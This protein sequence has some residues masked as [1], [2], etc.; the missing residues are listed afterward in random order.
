MEIFPV[1]F[2]KTIENIGSI[3]LLSLGPFFRQLAENLVGRQPGQV[4]LTKIGMVTAPGIVEKGRKRSPAL[5][6]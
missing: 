4:F 6:P 2:T 1:P 5:P 3:L